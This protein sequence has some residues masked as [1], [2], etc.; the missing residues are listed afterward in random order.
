MLRFAGG[1]DHHLIEEK[2]GELLG[3]RADVSFFGTL[4]KV[5]MYRVRNATRREARQSLF[6]DIETIYNR[7][8]RLSALGYVSPEQF[9]QAVSPFTR[10]HQT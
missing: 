4:K 9:E 10:A 5:L 7:I 2:A 3:R 8:R 1:T 6:E